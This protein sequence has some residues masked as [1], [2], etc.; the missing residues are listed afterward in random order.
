MEILGKKFWQ[1]NDV[2]ESLQ[3]LGFA[4]ATQWVIYRG[5]TVATSISDGPLLSSQLLPRITVAMGRCHHQT[6]A[7]VIRISIA[8]F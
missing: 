3:G 8:T 4:K 2:S 7:N 5:T 1:P 6:A